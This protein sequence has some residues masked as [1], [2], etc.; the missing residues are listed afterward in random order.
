MP[1]PVKM[2]VVNRMNFGVI[3]E[4]PGPG[5]PGR[6]EILSIL[7]LAG[8]GQ[9]DQ[10]LA[11]AAA[12]KPDQPDQPGAAP[13]APANALEAAS[14]DTVGAILLLEALQ[15]F[16]AAAARVAR[17]KDPGRRETALLYLGQA[18]NRLPFSAVLPWLEPSL[19][20]E[21]EVDQRWIFL[22]FEAR[23]DGFRYFEK[24]LTSPE[25]RRPA[26]IFAERAVRFEPART[27]A[28][29]RALP[30]GTSPGSGSSGFPGVAAGLAQHWP[31]LAGE[32]LKPEDGP[33]VWVAVAGSLAQHHPEKVIPVL[34]AQ[35]FQEPWD[36]AG[37]SLGRGHPELLKEIRT[38]MSPQAA[39]SLD[40]PQSLRN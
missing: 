28:L 10:A 19:A 27:V 5:A 14:H 38:R 15:N 9:V 30:E 33:E 1:A 22:A 16:P 40:Q 20:A 26:T 21:L 4:P 11:A 23:E 24:H 12:L 17:E 2:P 18:M 6:A 29:L 3:P 8:R 32:L 34:K 25:V 37:T 39:A 36:T 13:G 35:P 7:A 31:D